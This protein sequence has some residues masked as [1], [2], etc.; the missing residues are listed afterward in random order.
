MSALR[1]L[2]I[3]DGIFAWEDMRGFYGKDSFSLYQVDKLPF[4]LPNYAIAPCQVGSQL[5]LMGALALR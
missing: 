5:G 3:K 2:S 1:C 4:S